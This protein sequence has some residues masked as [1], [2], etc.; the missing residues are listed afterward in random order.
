VAETGVTLGFGR[1]VDDFGYVAKIDGSALVDP[2]HQLANVV[3]RLEKGIGGD[4]EISVEAVDG[5]GRRSSISALEGLVDLLKG[6]GV[7]GHFFRQ[8]FDPHLALPASGYVRSR[9]I[10]EFGEPPEH[11]FADA[12]QLMVV[13]SVGMEGEGDDRHI[14][15]LDGLDYPAFDYG[16][17]QVGVHGDLV[18]QFDKRFNLVFTDI[19]SD[20]DDG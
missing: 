16:R 17:Y 20:R 3:H 5:A 13:V 7:A 19:E 15:D 4:G 14:V 11:L 18:V 6:D 9:D 1:P 2:H 8:Q 10:F 12:A